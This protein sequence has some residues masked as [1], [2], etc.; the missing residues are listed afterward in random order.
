[1]Q[2]D[3]PNPCYDQ[4]KAVNTGY[5]LT[6]ITWLYRGLRYRTI[7]VKYFL[8]LSADKLLV[9]DERFV[10]LLDGLQIIFL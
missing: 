1:M 2:P 7:E 3:I 9:L 8:K 6:S 5:L 4:L 10:S